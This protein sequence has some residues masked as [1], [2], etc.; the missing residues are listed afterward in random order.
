LRCI[1]TEK[2]ITMDNQ[3]MLFFIFLLHGYM[4]AKN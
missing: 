2:F 1:F 4:S 3:D